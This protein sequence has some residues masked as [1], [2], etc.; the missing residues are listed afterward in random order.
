MWFPE[1]GPDYEAANPGLAEALNANETKFA[2]VPIMQEAL[3]Q[4]HEMYELG[5]F[6]EDVLSNVQ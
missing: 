3:Q 6:G 2:D 1:I 4:L 5:Y